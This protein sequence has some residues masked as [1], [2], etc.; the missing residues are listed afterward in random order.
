VKYIIPLIFGT[1]TLLSCIEEFR[2]INDKHAQLIKEEL[3]IFI[4][5]VQGITLCQAWI[6][7]KEGEP[8]IYFIN[9]P[10]AVDSSVPQENL[11]FTGENLLKIVCPSG[12]TPSVIDDTIRIS[13]KLIDY[14][15]YQTCR[16]N[17]KPGQCVTLYLSG[18]LGQVTFH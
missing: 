17:N 11:I 18:P 16:N 12:F 10:E 5:T 4:D 8:V 6:P 7:G 14:I 13:Y 2:G 15:E 9:N 1:I 3:S